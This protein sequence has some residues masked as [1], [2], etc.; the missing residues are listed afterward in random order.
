MKLWTADQ[1]VEQ[2]D[3]ALRLIDEIEEDHPHTWERGEEFM[4]DVREKL[5]D[6]RET[7]ENR[8][9]VTERQ[10]SAIEGW[11][12]GVKRWHPDHR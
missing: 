12:S 7:I 11:T 3:R 4:E 6:V 9:S 1:A 8:Q 2:I 10:Q 5:S